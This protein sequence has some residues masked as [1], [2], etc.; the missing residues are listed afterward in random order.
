MKIFIDNWKKNLCDNLLRRFFFVILSVILRYMENNDIL[1]NKY[2][3]TFC[4]EVKRNF[5]YATKVE[6]N[7]IKA[8]KNQRILMDYS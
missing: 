3:M 8:R 1:I 7:Y 6:G 5:G 4:H 2:F